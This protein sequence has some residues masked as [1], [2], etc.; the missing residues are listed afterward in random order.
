MLYFTNNELALGG[1]RLTD[2][3]LWLGLLL[4]LVVPLADMLQ[5]RYGLLKNMGYSLFGC[6]IFR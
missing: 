5:P 2:V 3:G 6:C 1:V 4:L